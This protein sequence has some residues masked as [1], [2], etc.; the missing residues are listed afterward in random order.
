MIKDLIREGWSYHDNESERLA[1][2]LEAAK[3]ND[4]EDD[5]LVGCLHLANHTLGE[6]LG[7]WARARRFAEAVCSAN[8]DYLG[9]STVSGRADAVASE[10]SDASLVEEYRCERLK[11]VG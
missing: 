7:D 3:L 8:Q 10:W 2:E 11:V 5:E 1:L 4:L 9:V 6:H